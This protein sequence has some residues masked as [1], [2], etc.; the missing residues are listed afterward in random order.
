MVRKFNVSFVMGSLLCLGFSAV[1]PSNAFAIKISPEEICKYLRLSTKELELRRPPDAN[2]R[3]KKNSELC[4]QLTNKALEYGK[5]KLK[6]SVYGKVDD[7]FEPAIESVLGKNVKVKHIEAALKLMDT[8]M[9]QPWQSS[10]E[11]VSVQSC[12]AIKVCKTL[13]SVGKYAHGKMASW[14]KDYGDSIYEGPA[15][16]QVEA[17]VLVALNE[18]VGD[19]SGL[20]S[21]TQN[22]KKYTICAQK[23]DGK[24]YR[25]NN[26]ELI[27]FAQ[28][29]SD[30]NGS[31]RYIP[32]YLIRHGADYGD[33]KALQEKM[34]NMEDRMYKLWAS[35]YD[36]DGSPLDCLMLGYP[37]KCL[38][39]GGNNLFRDASK[40]R[41]EM[42]HCSNNL[43]AE[44]QKRCIFNAFL[45]KA[46]SKKPEAALTNFKNHY[47]R[48]VKETMDQF[49]VSV[50]N[51]AIELN[52]LSVTNNDDVSQEESVDKFDDAEEIN[53][54][55]V[56]K[57]NK[58]DKNSSADGKLGECWD[59]S[60]N[61][62]SSS[63]SAK[64]ECI[65]DLNDLGVQ[66][67]KNKNTQPEKIKPTPNCNRHSCIRGWD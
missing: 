6:D 56:D 25:F 21:C 35:Y 47:V 54:N 63:N 24:T 44:E 22:S 39:E 20:D 51:A 23:G 58:E 46:V 49:S 40:Q 7:Y 1:A 3:I 60:G 33:S 11:Y 34:R 55:E 5:G 62:S 57:S 43:A 9:T 32:S 29:T 41:V 36:Y 10:L 59:D 67:T 4:K 15:Y 64:P 28:D 2:R 61:D 66:P 26:N 13:L 27:Q 48:K 53:G 52:N 12:E 31:G 16:N 8:F 50:T 37:D 38:D 19:F 18:G 14:I 45:H 65:M 30:P 17:L 42:P